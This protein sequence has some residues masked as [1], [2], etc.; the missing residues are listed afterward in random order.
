MPK[1]RPRASSEARIQP[2][3]PAFSLIEPQPRLKLRHFRRGV[4]R[5]VPP[6]LATFPPA[7]ALV[8][9]LLPPRKQCRKC[10]RIRRYVTFSWST[11]IRRRHQRYPVFV[12]TRE[13]VG[14]TME[15]SASDERR[16][17]MMNTSVNQG[18]AKIYQFPAGGRAALAGRR[19]SE[20]KTVA[21][22]RR[23]PTAAVAGTTRRP[24]RTQTPGVTT[25]VRE[26]LAGTRP[27]IAGAD[28]EL[29]KGRNEIVSALFHV[30]SH[31]VT[32]RLACLSVVTPAFVILRVTPFPE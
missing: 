19:N 18:S 7:H 12:T 15:A 6:P 27:A 5:G 31:V 25:D 32:G 20:T 4:R 2:N 13:R 17:D 10:L 26:C 3:S 21:E 9:R 29:E 24:S 22:H 23:S 28:G 30:C 1:R 14:R 8:I 16:D 11:C